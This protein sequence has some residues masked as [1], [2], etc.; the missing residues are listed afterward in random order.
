M[1][2]Y[3]LG[4]PIDDLSIEEIYTRVA[5]GNR[6]AHISINV[7]K[8]VLFHRNVIFRKLLSEKNVLF[9]VD[10][11]WIQWLARLSGIKAPYRFGGQEIIETF[12]LNRAGFDLPI[13]FL[14]STQEAVSLVVAML[15]KRFPSV[16]VSGY[17]NGFFNDENSVINEIAASKAKIVF[18]ALPSPKKELLSLKL[19][20]EIPR[21][22]FACG[23]GGIFD[24][25]AGRIKRAPRLIQTIGLEWLY[26]CC[27]EPFRLPKRYLNDGL[28]MV[29][30]IIAS[31]FKKADYLMRQD[32][33]KMA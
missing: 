3:V 8:I 18:L 23:V 15:K 17:R 7:H 2:N 22:R 26:R 9:S 10:G 30:I 24:V 21:L 13:F 14:G 6:Y 31:V 29:G 27:K 33:G 16:V 4:V 1:R 20:Q 19:L 5:Q 12:C 32:E 11:R 25:L 28:T